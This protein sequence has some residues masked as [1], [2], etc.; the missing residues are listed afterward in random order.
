[1]EHLGLYIKN[2]MTHKTISFVK[3]GIRIIGFI[4]LLQYFIL[5]I[6]LLII[7]EF[8]GIMEELYENC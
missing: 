6:F 5:G 3:S 1:M 4:V 7:A 2:N 8:L